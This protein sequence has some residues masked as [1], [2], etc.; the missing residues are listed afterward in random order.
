MSLHSST[1]LCIILFDFNLLAIALLLRY[2]YIAFEVQLQSFCKVKALLSNFNTIAL[3]W[4]IHFACRISRRLL[5][6]KR[7]I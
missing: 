1:I 3:R 7:Y 5:G 4:C 2:N 6:L